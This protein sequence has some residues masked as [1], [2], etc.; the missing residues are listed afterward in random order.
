MAI[1]GEAIRDPNFDPREYLLAFVQRWIMRLK[2]ETDPDELI[3]PFKEALVRYRDS[4]IGG[5]DL[6]SVRA[7]DQAWLRLEKIS[8]HHSHCY[9]REEW[10]KQW[11]REY[12]QTWETSHI[13]L[14][15]LVT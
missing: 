7:N 4:I 5:S 13:S 9:E 1:P 15:P 3:K 6:R 2:E 11:L 10:F 14:R 8:Y 12:G